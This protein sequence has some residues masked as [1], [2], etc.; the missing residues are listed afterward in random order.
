MIE[1]RKILE[2]WI[3]YLELEKLHNLKI[4]ASKLSEEKRK[5]PTNWK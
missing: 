5:K 4:D 1:Y 2:A 3:E